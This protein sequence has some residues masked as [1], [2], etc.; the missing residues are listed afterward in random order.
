MIYL[1][2]GP[3]GAGKTTFA[4]KLAAQ[5]KAVCFSEDEWL[6]RL[7]VPLAPEGLLQQP[8]QDVATWASSKYALCR[9]QIWSVAKQILDAGGGVVLDGAAANQAQRDLIRHKAEARGLDFKLYYLSANAN[10]RRR[11]ILARNK[12]QG[13]TYSLEV[14]PDMFAAMDISF[15]PP[16]SD[17]LIYTNVIDN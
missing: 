5:H 15:E 1:V 13:D 12:I 9:A 17:E 8:F 2:C 14:T 7:F 3:I 16:S 6:S 4:R 11:R 10:T